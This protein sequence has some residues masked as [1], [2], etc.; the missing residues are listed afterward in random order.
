MWVNG[1]YYRINSDRHGVD[2][3]KEI[4][5]VSALEKIGRKKVV[6]MIDRAAGRNLR[7]D[8]YPCDSEFFENLRA[9]MI[10]VIEKSL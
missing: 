9:E 4:K 7:F 2:I 10:E 1:K 8:D 6:E 5:Q 3:N